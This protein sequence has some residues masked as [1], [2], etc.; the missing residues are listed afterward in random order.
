VRRQRQRRLATLAAQRGRKGRDLPLDAEEHEAH[1]DEDGADDE[2]DGEEPG[3][4]RRAARDEEARGHEQARGG[5][6]GSAEGVDKPEDDD[7]GSLSRVRNGRRGGRGPAQ[8]PEIT[9]STIS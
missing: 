3:A 5:R 2:A 4:L 6:E 1:A 9:A 8:P 7:H